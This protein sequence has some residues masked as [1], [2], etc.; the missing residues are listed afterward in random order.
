MTQ[1]AYSMLGWMVILRDFNFVIV[2]RLT[3]GVCQRLIFNIFVVVIPFQMT[4][5]RVGIDLIPKYVYGLFCE[6]MDNC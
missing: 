6:R 4:H 5:L 2:T 1:R 3:R